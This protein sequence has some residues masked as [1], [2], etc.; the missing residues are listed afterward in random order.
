V[1]AI[2]SLPFPWIV[3]QDRANFFEG[4]IGGKLES[5]APFTV[6]V[7]N[8]KRALLGFHV[9][10]DVVMRSNPPGVPHLDVVTGVLMVLGLGFALRRDDRRWLLLVVLP[11]LLLLVPSV[12]VLQTP[13]EIPSASRTIATAPL[14]CLLA[15]LGLERAAA[16]LGRTVRPWLGSAVVGACLVAALALNVD[17]YF[18]RYVAALPY[19]NTPIAR[20]VADYVDRLPLGTTAYLVGCCWEGGMP[21]PKS[22]EYELAG[23]RRFVHWENPRRLDCA[24]LDG[25]DRP[26]VLIWS[27]HTP[28]PGPATAPC[29]AR[30]PAQVYSSERGLPVFVAAPL[31]REGGGEEP[32]TEAVPTPAPLVRG[33]GEGTI[34][35]DELVRGRGVAGGHPVEVTHSRLDIGTLDAL[36]DGDRESLIRGAGDN[37]FILELELAQGPVA[38]RSIRLELGHLPDFSITTR[39]ERV[40]AEPQEKSETFVGLPG[41]P[42]LDVVLPGDPAQP[43]ERVRIEVFDRTAIP[44]YGYHVHVRDLAIDAEARPGASSG[45]RSE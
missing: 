35:A 34:V 8:A 3:W 39:V 2:V 1:A 22:I 12:L 28:E 23:L 19:D 20:L 10:G 6:A 7:G 36:F 4:Y 30:L 24:A 27:F 37:P 13:H 41:E 14:A 5:S 40:G 17:R 25:L 29:R 16:A 33:D 38:L 9:R 43:V 21:E 31:L 45:S 18:R 32:I 44:D 42:V 26:A 15:A 11:L